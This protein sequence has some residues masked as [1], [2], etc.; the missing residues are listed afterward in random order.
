MRPVSPEDRTRSSLGPLPRRGR[1]LAGGTLAS[2][3][4]VLAG[5]TFPAVAAPSLASPQDKRCKSSHHKPEHYDDD[6]KAKKAAAKKP[7]KKATK[8]AAEAPAQQQMSYDKCKVGPTGPRGPKGDRGPRGPQGEQGDQ[9]DPGEQGRRGPTGPTGPQ[10]DPGEQGRRGPTGP[11]GPQGEQGPRGFTGP[12]GPQGEPG[13]CSDVDAVVVGGIEGHEVKSVLTGGRTYVGLRE[14]SPTTNWIWY[15]L[16]D[17]ESPDGRPTYPRSACATAVSAADGIVHVEVLT[18]EGEVWETLCR[19][20]TTTN[21]D[22]LTC[23]EQWSRL[24]SQPDPGDPPPLARFG[25]QP[26]RPADPNH[27]P[28]AMK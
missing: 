25:D 3:A 24:P 1:W 17:T 19:I 9:G 21:P 27:A 26:S 28:K 16:T 7:A 23:N 14:L 15:D 18:R 22:S 8:R 2:V 13:P 10:G 6:D 4:L 20:N 5:V 11:T 12:T